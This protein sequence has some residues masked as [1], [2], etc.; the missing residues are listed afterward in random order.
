MTLVEHLVETGV[1]LSKRVGFIAESHDKTGEWCPV[2]LVSDVYAQ[3]F[4][5]MQRV[6]LKH[7]TLTPSS[8][9]HFSGKLGMNVTFT[10]FV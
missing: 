5:R 6:M 10:F 7:K 4:R 2:P 8:I 1:V 3:A 9:S